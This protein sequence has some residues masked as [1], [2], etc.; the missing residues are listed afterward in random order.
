MVVMNWLY[1]FP[2][3]V[4]LIAFS[5]CLA[6]VILGLPSLVRRVPWMKPSDINTDFVLRMQ[7]T[8]FT[9]TSLVLAF[10]LVEAENNFRKVDALVST[11]ASQLNRLDR[12]LNRY[13][14][15]A[16]DAVRVQLL[17]YAQSIVSEEWPAMLKRIPSEKTRAA[18]VPISRGILS[19]D[20]KTNR[21]TMIYG[22]ILRSFDAVAESR[23]ARLA[24]V[25]VALPAAYWQVVLF[26][27]LVL[28]FVSSTVE[29]TP[30]RATVIAA[31]MAVIGAFLGFV[32]IQDQPFKGQMAVDA[33]PIEQAIA[34]I[35]NRKGD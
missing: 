11:E 21:Q 6:A 4:I 27:V 5:A 28:L 35:K 14:D 10:T 15:P 8:L 20:P 29:R 32:F 18:F 25:S 33:E 31:Q 3:L 12:L 19:L 24:A 16:A 2:D 1:S 34:I 30:F 23:D 17:A 13:G 7:A 22:E 9:M 26:A